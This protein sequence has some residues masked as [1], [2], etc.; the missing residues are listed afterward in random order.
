MAKYAQRCIYNTAHFNFTQKIK[1][2]IRRIK[3]DFHL[4][5][6]ALQFWF[7]RTYLDTLKLFGRSSVDSITILN[8]NP[9]I[10]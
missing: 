7:I 5:K 6:I 9:Q 3:F 1:W 2:I 8:Y 4:A 10:E